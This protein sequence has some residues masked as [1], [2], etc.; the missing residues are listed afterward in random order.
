MEAFNTSLVRER[1]VFSQKDEAPIIIRSNRVFLD[2]KGARIVVR[3]QHMHMTLRLASR[4]LTSFYAGTTFNWDKHWAAAQS[5]YDRAHYSDAW[6]ALY[7][8]GEAAFRTQQSPFT[9]IVEKCALLSLGNYDGTMNVASSAL[10]KLGREVSIDHAS[11]IAT[12]IADTGTQLR[13]G[14]IHRGGERDTIFSFTAA[15]GEQEER[16]PKC[17]WIAADYLES[18]NLQF[19]KKKEQEKARA[20]STRQT[21]LYKNI[22]AFEKEYDV[23]YRPDKPHLGE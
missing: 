19:I 12:T 16:V 22:A 20:A 18:F 9:D 4:L 10:K 2:L 7:V 13:C 1:I 3:A 23:K 15:N 8:N 5:D 17:L 21:A 11:A 6:C 14:I